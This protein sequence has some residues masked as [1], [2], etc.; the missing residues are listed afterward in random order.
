VKYNLLCVGV[1]SYA[2][3]RFFASK[4]ESAATK[5]AALWTFLL[6]FRWPFIASV[7]LFGIAY[8]N[9]MGKGVI[10]ELVPIGVRGLL[11]SGKL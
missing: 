9:T 11:V 7:A 10:S 5:M 3:Q 1:T 8:G 4:N 6:C 2:E